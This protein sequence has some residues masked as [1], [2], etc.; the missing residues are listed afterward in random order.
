VRK[1]KDGLVLADLQGPGVIYRIWTPTPTDDMLEFYFD[2]E[3]RPS[4]KVKF[5]DLFLGKHHVFVRPLVG[6]GVGGFFSYVPLT[7][8][9]SCK[10]FIRAESLQFYQINY[11]TYP[12][13][14]PIVSFPKQPANE[15]KPHLDKA[16]ELFESCGSDVSSYAIPPVDR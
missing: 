2:S 5:R 7:Y 4:I 8:K 9:K 1:E 10:V 11:T 16:I 3:N 15:Y 6:Y 13:E 12:E 14:T